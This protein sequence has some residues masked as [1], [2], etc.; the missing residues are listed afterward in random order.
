MNELI[1]FQHVTGLMR[2]SL[3]G[4]EELLEKYGVD[5]ARR[6]SELL[7]VLQEGEGAAI[8]SGQVRV[9]LQ[10]IALL[11]EKPRD[12]EGDASETV[13]LRTVGYDDDYSAAELEN[14]ERVLEVMQGRDGVR[15]LVMR[16]VY[17]ARWSEIA[18]DLGV[19]E[20]KARELAGKSAKSLVRGYLGRGEGGCGELDKRFERV[21]FGLYGDAD[22]KINGDVAAVTGHEQLCQCC[23]R[24]RTELTRLLNLVACVLPPRSD[25][26]RVRVEA[27]SGRSL[28]QR[29][30]AV[31]AERVV[32]AEEEVASVA[33]PAPVN[34]E[35]AEQ[36]V[37]V[38]R[39]LVSVAVK[40]SAGDSSR[41]DFAKQISGEDLIK[42]AERE[43]GVDLS[44]KEVDAGPAPV[45]TAAQIDAEERLAEVDEAG[46]DL[47][48][49]LSMSA[50]ED[51]VDPAWVA[52][53]EE[54]AF[55]PEGGVGALQA[56]V[57]AAEVEKIVVEFEEDELEELPAAA[58]RVVVEFEDGELEEVAAE[59]DELPSER[60]IVDFDAA[61]RE[62]IEAEEAALEAQEIVVEFDQVEGDEEQAPGEVVWDSESESEEGDGVREEVWASAEPPAALILDLSS[63][64]EASKAPPVAVRP[65]GVQNDEDARAKETRSRSLAAVSIATA[66]ATQ[67]WADS[68][69][70]WEEEDEERRAYEDPRLL[71]GGL[72]GVFLALVLMVGGLGDV[73]GG[74]AE[75]TPPEAAVARTVQAPKAEKKKERPKKKAK[76]KTR[77]RSVKVA[78]VVAPVQSA[79]AAPA[80]VPS[81]GAVDDG[82]SEF[83]PEARG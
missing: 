60:V 6:A 54:E 43:L 31:F 81:S 57:E 42:S 22:K 21:V 66:S 53:R 41:K 40:E 49:F 70:C 72:I 46:E 9:V 24:D 69:E 67:E 63:A 45:F 20:R 78:P 71:V 26:D 12:P 16:G 10:E 25:V 61:E 18:E 37:E 74:K 17:G 29:L 11:D 50:L 58:E 82:S 34:V 68:G 13:S 19:S 3:A 36:E 65:R 56:E 8:V 30:L 62:A 55:E 4:E 76:K 15:A 35:R 52:E 14:C 80:P 28:G 7:R 51:L 32:G 2:F 75:G 77:A 5:D 64:R 59:V 79:P 73:W 39:A 83:L 38:S 48:L 27:R 44:G 1:P 23:S 47:D 33:P